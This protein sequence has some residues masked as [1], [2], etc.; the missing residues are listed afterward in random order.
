MFQNAAAYNAGRIIS[1]TII[2]GILGGIGAF[3]G[4]AGTLQT[5]S[6]FQG[7]LKLLAGAL[8]VVMGINML[9][10]F[11]G[12]RRFHL[13]ISLPLFQKG[14]QKNASK[15]ISKR[16]NA[17]HRRRTP[18]IIGLF[19]G[20]MPCGPLQSMQIVALA[21]ANSFTGALSMFFFALGTIPLMLGFGSIV[22]GLGKHFTKQVLKC[23]AILVV[24]MGL[25]MMSQ[26]TALS[27]MSSQINTLFSANG[28]TAV[29]TSDRNDSDTDMEKQEPLSNG[30]FTLKKAVLT[31]ATIRFCCQILIP[32]VFLRKA[33]IQL[34]L[35][36]KKLVSIPIAVGWA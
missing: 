16:S 4:M 18:F 12:L 34:N 36:L 15:G 30:L 32:N 25:S 28:E 27:G 17:S 13:R 24:V 14:K 35:H 19:N 23:G 3:T 5:S 22:A 1:Y 20:L 8:M 29:K 33:T 9:G 11:P 21:S 31:A 26:G 7:L 10:L 6:F 2:G